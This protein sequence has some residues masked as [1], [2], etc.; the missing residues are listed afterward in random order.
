MK[1]ENSV[2]SV[3]NSGAGILRRDGIGRVKT[4][5]DRREALLDEF[6][7]SGLQGAEFA[8]MAGIKYQTFAAWVQ[9]RRH[10][11]GEYRRR[12]KKLMEVKPLCLVEATAPTQLP[13]NGGKH[14]HVREVDLLQVQLPGGA[15]ALVAGNHQTDILAG[16]LRSLQ[17][18]EGRRSC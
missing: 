4:P 9:R 15:V 10:E 1:K 5:R 12:G 13:Q 14:E 16:L 11:R 17:S 6:E 3:E 2:G 18:S 7:K 8:Q